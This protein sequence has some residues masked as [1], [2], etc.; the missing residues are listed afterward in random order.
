MG[1]CCAKNKKKLKKGAIA[2]INSVVI[3][4]KITLRFVTNFHMVG[5]IRF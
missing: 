2:F 3:S 1:G 5:L 4:V